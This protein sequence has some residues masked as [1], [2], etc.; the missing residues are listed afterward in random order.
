MCERNLNSQNQFEV[1]DITEEILVSTVA[2][3]KLNPNK[4]IVKDD[5][6]FY[7]YDASDLA[8]LTTKKL[9][10]MAIRYYSEHDI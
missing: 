2:E 8:I 9:V 6:S 3:A 10:S 7:G 4:F 5:L 1:K